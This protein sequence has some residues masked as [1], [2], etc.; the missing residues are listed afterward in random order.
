METI[1]RTII[2]DDESLAR[3][4]LKHRLLAGPARP[5]APPA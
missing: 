2:V 3:R 1:L 4:G 5:Q